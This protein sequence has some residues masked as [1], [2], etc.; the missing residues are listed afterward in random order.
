MLGLSNSLKKIKLSQF[1]QGCWSP[2][3]LGDERLYGLGVDALQIHA[4]QCLQ[5]PHGFRSPKS[6]SFSTS[7]AAEAREQ[8]G[9]L[10]VG[11]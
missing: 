9:A 10:R 2:Y 1:G 6:C 11:G 3:A 8:F 7:I 5:L 4:F